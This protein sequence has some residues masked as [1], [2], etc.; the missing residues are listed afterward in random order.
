[1]SA[2][3]FSSFP[4]SFS[5]FPDVGP[6]P[7]KQ[8]ADP[9]PDNLQLSKE[10][11]R[12][13][14]DGKQDEH[15]RQGPSSKR[16]RHMKGQSRGSR[17]SHNLSEDG[18]IVSIEGGMPSGSDGLLESTTSSSLFYFTDRKGDALNLQYG[19]LHSGSVP[20]YYLAARGK[21][22][23]GLNPLWRV[24]HRGRKGVEIAA[25]GRRKMHALTDPSSRHLLHSAPTRMLRASREDKY[26][27]DEAEGFLPLVSKS[28]QAT[29]QLYRSIISIEGEDSDS[30]ASTTSQGDSSDNDSDSVPMSALQ[31]TLKELE[32]QLTAE[33]SSVASWLSLLSYTLSTVPIASKN[34]R[35]AR[36]EISLSVLSRAISAHPSNLSSKS[37]RLRYLKAGEEVW[38]ENKLDAEWEDALKVGGV[39]LWMEWLEWK[40]KKGT[41]GVE[42]MVAAASRALFSLGEDEIGKLRVLWRTAVGLLNAGYVE[43]AAALFQAQAELTYKLPPLMDTQPFDC[44]LDSLEEFWDSEVPRIGEINAQ[45]WD[46]WVIS[47]HKP[48]IPPPRTTVRPPSLNADPF[49]RWEALER[50]SDSVHRLP[51]RSVHDFADIDPYSVVLFSDIRPLLVRIASPDAK[52]AL[53]FIWLSFLGLH[54]PG[55]LRTLSA[56][57]D[58][59]MDDRW[60][61]THFAQSSFLESILP[62]DGL[63]ASKRITADSHTGVLV[64]RERQYT[65]SFGPVKNWGFNVLGPFDAVTTHGWRMWDREDVAGVDQQIVREVFAQCRFQ[66]DPEWDV[67]SLA[68]EASCSMKSALKISKHLLASR[69]DS[70]LLWA[71]HAQLERLRGRLDDARKIYQT[72]LSASSNSGSPEAMHMWWDWAEM[73]WLAGG[74]DVAIEVLVRSTAGQGTSGVAIL[75]AKRYL[76]ESL[77]ITSQETWKTRE[78]RLKIWALL[79]LLTASPH[80]ALSVF[81]TQISKLTPQTISHESMT[82]ASV[83]FLYN[84]SAVL[85]NPMPPALFRERAE[86]AVDLYPNNTVLLGLF[87][88]AEKGRGIW[89]R[90]RAMLSENT[91]TPLLKEKDIMRRMAETWVTGWGIGGWEAEQERARSGLSAAVQSERTR[92][93]AILWRLYVEFEIKMGQLERAKRLL[94]RALGECPLVKGKQLYLLA[95]GPL[96]SVIS[97]RELREWA[98]TM[99]ERGIRMRNGLE[100]MLEGWSEERRD[101]DRGSDAEDEIEYNAR[102]LR[103]LRP[104]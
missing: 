92:G 56:N 33:P 65:K 64:G 90:V 51:S 34:A 3:S 52:C 31:V 77:A 93:S 38:H 12:K 10:Q 82:A 19:G 2:P 96:R 72:V 80:S 53:R 75:R 58:D 4:P 23:L 7:S 18:D 47:T 103:R 22:I 40:I 35:K 95:F 61:Y 91:G 79:E 81:D 8:Q 76:Q 86:R 85:R 63:V 67:L 27:Y 13:K 44:Q 29:S 28:D 30:D 54:V 9:K 5:S 45:G 48:N 46:K 41:K 102:E 100:E 98:E 62:S 73:E 69:Q 24:I 49:R 17:E 70:L 84:H 74:S 39:E 21:M 60:A 101:D 68:F 25:G 16:K 88:E 66:D 1:M 94:F 50:W 71:S 55:F 43:R 89:G 37:L 32:E 36:S 15:D 78:L 20:R 57:P 104:Y 83:L 97:G 26:Q 42:T 99:A 14:R 59:N 87:L 11:K 6:G